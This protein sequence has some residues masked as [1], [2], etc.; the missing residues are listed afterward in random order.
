MKENEAIVIKTRT[1]P[2]K[3]KL[4][5][6]WKI[7]WGTAKYPADEFVTRI[8]QPIH[9]FDLKSFVQEQQKINL[10]VC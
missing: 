7:D 1:R 5:P 6:N 10:W 3:T 2:F 9:T 4:K 8:K